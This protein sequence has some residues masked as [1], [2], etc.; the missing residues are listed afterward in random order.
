M[1]EAQTQPTPAPEEEL[2]TPPDVAKT[3]ETLKEAAA[4]TGA[5]KLDATIAAMSVAAQHYANMPQS[6]GS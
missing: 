1:E 6:K 2:S 5:P 4:A 3:V